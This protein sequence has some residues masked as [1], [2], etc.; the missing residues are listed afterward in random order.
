M[1]D[2]M[3]MGRPRKNMEGRIDE[4]AVEDTSDLVVCKEGII[5]A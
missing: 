1:K 3:A 4:T 5:I 2:R